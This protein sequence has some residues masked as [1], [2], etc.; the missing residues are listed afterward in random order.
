MLRDI[1][2]AIVPCG[3]GSEGHR[4]RYLLWEL[5]KIGAVLGV[6]RVGGR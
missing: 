4:L 1:P 5:V 2:I 3:K 6:L